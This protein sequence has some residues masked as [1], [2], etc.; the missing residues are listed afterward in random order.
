M[1]LR[2]VGEA[3]RIRRRGGSVLNSKSEFNRCSIVRL[4]IPDQEDP[5]P[6]PVGLVVIPEVD[7]GVMRACLGEVTGL[8]KPEKSVQIKRQQSHPSSKPCKRASQED[9]PEGWELESRPPTEMTLWWSQKSQRAKG[10]VRKPIQISPKK[11]HFE[12]AALLPI[13]KIT[14]GDNGVSW[15]PEDA[16]R[17]QN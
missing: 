15:T 14:T 17:R 8:G 5:P 6:T 2:Q 13:A 12:T 1:W 16:K 10:R 3:V 4:T 11:L 7:C 9:I